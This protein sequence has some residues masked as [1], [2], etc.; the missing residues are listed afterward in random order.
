MGQS[1]EIKMA[2]VSFDMAIKD[3]NSAMAILRQNKT[4]VADIALAK[5]AADGAIKF[6]FTALE[7]LKDFEKIKENQ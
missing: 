4:Y 2:L 6:I 7:K 3:I 5:E 1:K